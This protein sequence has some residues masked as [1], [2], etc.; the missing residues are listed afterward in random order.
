MASNSSQPSAPRWA[1]LLAASPHR[2]TSAVGEDNAA[3][4]LH[5]MPAFP[6]GDHVETSELPPALEGVNPKVWRAFGAMFDV[7]LTAVT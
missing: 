2:G 3:E 5:A 6:G 1:A 4:N 7:K